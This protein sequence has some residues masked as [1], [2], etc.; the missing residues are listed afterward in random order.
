MKRGTRVAIAIAILA[1]GGG[2]AWWASHREGER[3]RAERVEEFLLPDRVERP[4]LSPARQHA[5]GWLRGRAVDAAGSPVEGVSVE[6][7][8]SIEAG[9]FRWRSDVRALQRG[10]AQPPAVIRRVT[11]ADGRFIVEGLSQGEPHLLWLDRLGPRATKRFLTAEFASA[12][13]REFGDVRLNAPRS[14]RGRVTTRDGKPVARAVVRAFGANESVAPDP[15][16]VMIELGPVLGENRPFPSTLLLRSSPD[17]PWRISEPMPPQ[18]PGES[19]LGRPATTTADDGTFELSGDLLPGDRI[20]VDHPAFVRGTAAVPLTG[21]VVLE[22]GDELRGF[23]RDESGAGVEG[24]RVFAGPIRHALSVSSRDARFVGPIERTTTSSNGAFVVSGLDERDDVAVVVFTPDAVAVGER[25]ANGSAAIHLLLEARATLTIRARGPDGT[26]CEN[27]RVA[28]ENADSRSRIDLRTRLRVIERGVV[29][30]SALLPGRYRLLAESAGCARHDS[31]L[32]LASGDRGAAEVSFTRG[33]SREIRVTAADDGTPV[34]GAVVTARGAPRMSFEKELQL[35]HDPPACVGVTGR[36]GVARLDRLPAGVIAVTVEHPEFVF[37]SLRAPF[38][39]APLEVT[40]SRGGRIVGPRAV[41]RDL[42]PFLVYL[43]GES[44]EPQRITPS[45]DGSFTI[46]RLRPG[47]YSL[48]LESVEPGDAQ[49]REE[50]L[51]FAGKTT[52]L[53]RKRCTVAEGATTECEFETVAGRIPAAGR[54]RGRVEIDG[55]PAKGRAVSID[56]D[57]S[58][59]Q[60]TDADGRFEFFAVPVGPVSISIP[61]V[62]SN[63]YDSGDVLAAKSFD[64]AAGEVAE[65]EFQISTGSIAGQVVD[66]E[67]GSPVARANVV[68]L[69][70]ALGD[71]EQSVRL[72]TLSDADG[73]FVIDS[74]P[75]GSMLL[76][77]DARGYC[78]WSTSIEVSPRSANAQ[79][80]AM[81]RLERLGSVRG[82]IELPPELLN[83]RDLVLLAW[84]RGAESLR[85]ERGAEPIDVRFDSGNGDFSVDDVEPG[86]YSLLVT[87]AP[88]LDVE[89][90]TLTIKPGAHSGVVLRPAVR[91]RPKPT[92]IGGTIRLPTDTS[93]LVSKLVLHRLDAV[94]DDLRIGIQ[95]DGGLR[96]ASPLVV[97]GRYRVTLEP[98]GEALEPLEIDVPEGGVDKLVLEFVQRRAKRG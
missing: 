71:S 87:G 8:D 82:R 51:S 49:T 55:A 52:T 6:V 58:L 42:A 19:V 65:I 62:A 73:R 97:P 20:V 31:E 25:R 14:V 54:I 67:T 15:D 72:R 80:P 40:M 59:T 57:S 93:R 61:A 74:V 96:F 21:D 75:A 26:A 68:L 32:S 70:F 30:V 88:E 2:G 37:E 17:G 4:P 35:L 85:P 95:L 50:S 36:D 3:A 91:P 83:S 63:E 53:E 81:V 47:V 23:V 86:E 27:F 9:G 90:L 66:A 77:V 11:A 44:I 89:R 60:A 22:R 16:F 69:A 76:D 43:R 1:L 45:P 98:D 13:E 78:D 48:A 92:H 24:A 18:D 29:E 64:V 41:R 28:L 56:L 94:A 39:E 33:A 10:P 38:S 46:E 84:P 5:L 12:F 7:F 79:A 34:D